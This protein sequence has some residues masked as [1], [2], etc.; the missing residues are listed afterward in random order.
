MRRTSRRILKSYLPATA[1]FLLL[2][3][4][5]QGPFYPFPSYTELLPADPLYHYQWGMSLLR[6]GGAWGLLEASTVHPPPAKITGVV[7]IID[8]GLAAGHPDLV[9]RLTGDGYDLVA[10]A[11]IPLGN[12]E[13][14]G[15]VEHG[16]HT[17][18]I[19]VA[20]GTNG[21]GT[22]GIGGIGFYPGHE[23]RVTPLK[24]L[25]DATSVGYSAGSFDDLA[26]ALLYAAGVENDTGRTPAI[27]ASVINMSLGAEVTAV[28]EWQSAFLEAAC[29]A[30]ARTG[31]ILISAA[32]N[33]DLSGSGIDG[34]IDIP[35]VYDSVLAVQSP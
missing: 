8:S 25:T 24:V 23:V 35:A 10:D 6:V 1:L 12:E 30:A 9:G 13:P 16:T 15:S 21:L 26:T 31:A 3:G 20:G 18:G 32:G 27:P 28:S 22:V 5:R 33:G 34:G 4:C 17:A 11:P 2:S 29:I 7:A 19:I 14:A